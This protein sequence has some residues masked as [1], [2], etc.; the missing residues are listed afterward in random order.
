[1]S[2]TEEAIDM[3]CELAAAN[4]VG[5]DFD[6]LLK[7]LE[8]KGYHSGKIVNN[9]KAGTSTVLITNGSHE[10]RL[11]YKVTFDWKEKYPGMSEPNKVVACKWI[12]PL[13]PEPFEVR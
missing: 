6:V 7:E 8:A 9:R 4:M 11:Q 13:R 2:E 3:S 1:M 10:T 12:K 5:K